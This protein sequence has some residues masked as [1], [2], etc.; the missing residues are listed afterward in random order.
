MHRIPRP[1]L[2]LKFW[3]MSAIVSGALVG[4]RG[5]DRQNLA[6]GFSTAQ[7]RTSVPLTAKQ[8]DA[9]SGIVPVYLNCE[10]T[11][12]ILPDTLEGIPCTIK[13]NSGKRIRA[14]V[15][16][17]SVTVVNNGTTAT[18]LGY[19]T[20]DNFIHPDFHTEGIAQ[21]AEPQFPSASAETYSGTITQVQVHIDF[22]EFN[23]GETLGPNKTGERILAGMRDGAAKYKSWLE[24]QYEINGRSSATLARLIE[25]GTPTG[26]DLGVGSPSQE[27]GAMI[28]QKWLRKTYQA[29]GV[30]EIMKCLNNSSS[31]ITQ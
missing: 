23:D 17:E 3:I 7:E 29:K 15:L 5:A 9:V 21:S 22:V 26:A 10:G 6:E 1:K 16:G 12:L 14:L 28:Y 8:L 24:K 30:K 27:Q 18:E 31:R 11:V 19:V 4:F 20:I 2:L 13:N 25:D